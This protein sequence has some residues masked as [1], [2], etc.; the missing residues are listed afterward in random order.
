MVQDSYT[1]VPSARVVKHFPFSI[2]GVKSFRK[3]LAEMCH[4]RMTHFGKS[5]TSYSSF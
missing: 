2:Q 3:K 1:K 5:S 4:T